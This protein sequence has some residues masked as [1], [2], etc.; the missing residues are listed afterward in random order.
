MLAHVKKKV[1]NGSTTLFWKDPW[2]A[3]SPLINS[4]PRLFAL[5]CNKNATVAD[6]IHDISMSHSFRRSP[7]GGVEEEQYR[8]LVDKV[9]SV[10]LSNTSDTWVWSIDS[11]GDFS[12]KFARSL[13]DD[14]ILPAV[15]SPTRWVKVV[16]IKINIFAWK[17]CLDRLLT[18]LNLSLRGI[19]SP[20]ISCPI[21]SSVGETCA[22]LLFSC[23]MAKAHYSKV[24]RWCKMEI[25]VFDSY[26]DWLNWFISL[27]FSKAFKD[28]LEG[29]RRL[30]P[31]WGD[32]V[33][34]GGSDSEGKMVTGWRSGDDDGVRSDSS[35]GEMTKVVSWSGG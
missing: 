19:D 28:M 8:S 18:R 1:G 12:V 11:S 9:N 16:P 15:V 35:G 2:F 3:D 4:F 29:V 20:S 31:W 24:A 6:K 21:C 13:I 32:G 7:R 33:G 5:E 27:R 34:C 30:L 17:V 23:S 10:V 14:F 26:E 22:H 25:P